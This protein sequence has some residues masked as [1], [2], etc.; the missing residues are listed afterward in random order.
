MVEL[1]KSHKIFLKIFCHVPTTKNNIWYNW[2]SLL[3]FS[4]S[5]YKYS[6]GTLCSV[7]VQLMQIVPLTHINVKYFNKNAL[8]GNLQ[9]I[10]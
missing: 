5:L 6:K 4:P 1:R 3:I 9:V 10:L 2:V 7:V 8:W